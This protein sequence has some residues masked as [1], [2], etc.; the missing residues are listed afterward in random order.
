MELLP[1]Y[2]SYKESLT[3]SPIV[4]NT[5]I[6]SL[7]I[8]LSW[9]LGWHYSGFL[10]TERQKAYV[11]SLLS[12]FLT[13]IGSLPLVYQVLFIKRGNILNLLDT[14]YETWSLVTTVFFMTFLVL[15]LSI[16][17]ILY[18]KQIGLLTGWIHH[19]TY[20]GLLF[21]VMKKRYTGLFI[22]MCV[23][24]IP[25]FLLALGSIHK[26]FR[27]DY[28][29]A[30]TFVSTRILFHA[31]MILNTFLFFH[32]HPMTIALTAFFPLHCYWFYGF[33]LQQKRISKEKKNKVLETE[34]S[35][36]SATLCQSNSS[37]IKS[38]SENEILPIS[39]LS[40]ST[41]SFNT[42]E[43]NSS[44]SSS[45]IKLNTTLARRKLS[46]QLR[47]H[48]PTTI[49]SSEDLFKNLPVSSQYVIQR[50]ADSLPETL[51]RD[52]TW[53]SEKLKYLWEKHYNDT[54][55]PPSSPVQQH[56]TPP[57]TAVAAH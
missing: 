55:P 46:S 32:F 47:R 26:P 57:N 19:I 23:L 53:S 44:S 27:N 41:S 2:S 12:S 18:R 36:L 15:D 42:I 30:T 50:L 40:S 7:V 45:S 35:S 56:N 29:F 48:L 5:F 39:L 11:F 1:P 13:S 33:I 49:P 38:T 52:L 16:G 3:F 6:V 17:S 28:V 51:Q 10:K 4:F 31:F 22:T 43:K 20:L 9:Y 25:T 34:K 24:E 37:E 8:Q 21:W 14:T 54:T